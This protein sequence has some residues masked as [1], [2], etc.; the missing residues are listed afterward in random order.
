MGYGTSLIFGGEGREGRLSE[1]LPDAELSTGGSTEIWECQGA[2]FDQE[3]KNFA[4][5]AS[6]RVSKA[7]SHWQE[8]VGYI[9]C[10]VHSITCRV[11][12]LQGEEPVGCIDCRV[13]SLQDAEL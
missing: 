7:A 12:S 1:S 6:L 8:A 4:E 9:N 3:R 2:K 10:G 5:A 13:Q 11:Q